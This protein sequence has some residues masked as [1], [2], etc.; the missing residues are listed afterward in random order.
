[1]SGLSHV[2]PLDYAQKRYQRSIDRGRGGSNPVPHLDPQLQTKYMTADRTDEL[3]LT[4]QCFIASPN[5]TE[6]RHVPVQPTQQTQPFK[7][8]SPNSLGP[9]AYSPHRML[10]P[11]VESPEVAYSPAQIAQFKPKLKS[12][13]AERDAATVERDEAK[14][15]RENM[16][17]ELLT[18]EAKLNETQVELTRYKNELS[19]LRG[20]HSRQYSR[21]G[22]NINSDTA[23]GHYEQYQE[24]PYQ[25][26]N[27]LRAQLQRL[28]QRC[29][30]AEAYAHQLQSQQDTLTAQTE[31]H[32]RAADSKATQAISLVDFHQSQADTYLRQL[33]ELRES[34]SASAAAAEQ[35]F[36]KSKFDAETIEKLKTAH[37]VDL[38][39]ARKLSQFFKM[40]SETAAKKHKE[41]TLETR[42]LQD[43]LHAKNREVEEQKGLIEALKLQM[44]EMPG[45]F[46]GRG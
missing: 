33:I 34:R 25:S 23:N 37:T 7:A 1:M 46:P 16:L 3:K 42:R 9:N 40:N 26:D 35:E 2:G 29:A 18:T 38:D 36:Q 13:R 6:I 45:G 28:Q 12:L 15:D 31:Q 39:E 41:M 20:S 19:S 14:A 43:S 24:Q 5:S 10:D 11:K 27:H 4:T 30:K 32:L 17:T 21:G 22:G 44:G 8:Y